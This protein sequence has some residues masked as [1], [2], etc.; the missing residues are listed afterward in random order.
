MKKTNSGIGCETSQ[1]QSHQIKKKKLRN[2][3]LETKTKM[4]KNYNIG[5][6]L[7]TTHKLRELN[8][9][10]VTFLSAFDRVV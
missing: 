1:N 8:P 10:S 9:K 2:Q 6:E 5:C 7:N 3:Y 4:N